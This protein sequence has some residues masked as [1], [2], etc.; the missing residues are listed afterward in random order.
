MVARGDVRIGD[1]V[2]KGSVRSGGELTVRS[3]GGSRSG[4]IV[5]G[6]VV[7]T[8]AITADAVGSE[9]GLPTRVGI[10][11]DLEVKAKLIKLDENIGFANAN[12]LRIFRTLKIE[13]LEP[14][15]VKALLRRTLAAR[16]AAIGELL[17]KLRELVGYKDESEKRRRALAAS[18]EQTLRK[19]EISVS[20]R[21]H[22]GVQVAIGSDTTV[23]QDALEAPVFCLGSTGVTWRRPASVANGNS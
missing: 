4:S 9:A 16:R 14:G 5:G 23:I 8:R 10:G 13:S 19:A 3:G 2:F 6:E 20:H 7:A 1:H 11:D 15:P 22:A 12:A 18:A 17:I 21:A